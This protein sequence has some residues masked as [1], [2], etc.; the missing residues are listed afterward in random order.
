MAV[1]L[2]RLADAGDD[3]GAAQKLRG[4][5]RRDLVL[6][7]QF[8][9]DPYLVLVPDL[10]DHLRTPQKVTGDPPGDLL[11]LGERL[12]RADLLLR[13]DGLDDL[14]PD[15]AVGLVRRPPGLALGRGR[16]RGEP[17]LVVADG[18]QDLVDLGSGRTCRS[19]AFRP[20]RAGASGPTAGSSYPRTSPRTR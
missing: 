15:P 14:A 10:R 20:R 2:V 7:R 5:G 8:L 18:R 1:D 11:V 19:A 6:S 17:F 4:D 3:R 16:D 12:D 13:C 9:H